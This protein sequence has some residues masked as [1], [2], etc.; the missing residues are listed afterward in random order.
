MFSRFIQKVRVVGGG[1][2]ERVKEKQI[3]QEL[4]QWDFF[5]IF[6]C[7]CAQAHKLGVNIQR[8]SGS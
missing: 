8:M 4:C 7:E 5:L 6:V 2:R 1:K 3:V